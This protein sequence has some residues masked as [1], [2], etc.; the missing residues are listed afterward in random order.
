MQVKFTSNISK[1]S[2]AIFI[3]SS[4]KSYLKETGIE[5]NILSEIYKAIDNKGFNFNKG[6]VIEINNFLYK[7]TKSIF[8]YGLG[9]KLSEVNYDDFEQIG[10]KVTQLTK[11]K[12]R[13][14]VIKTNLL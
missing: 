12:K 9:K 4:N 10:G 2:D 11:S 5:K 7:K 1:T 6:E 14:K 13:K 3:I 8:V